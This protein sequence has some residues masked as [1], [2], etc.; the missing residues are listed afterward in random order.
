M[1]VEKQWNGIESRNISSHIWLTN[2]NQEQRQFNSKRVVF[3]TDGA[4][5]TGFINADKS[6]YQY[7]TLYYK[8]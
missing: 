8:K 5:T 1:K 2:V 6:L 3:P 4:G 7:Q